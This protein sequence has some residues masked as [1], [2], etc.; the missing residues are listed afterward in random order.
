[1]INRLTKLEIALTMTFSRTLYTLMGCQQYH[2]LLDPMGNGLTK[3]GVL[4]STLYLLVWTLID[5]Q[6]TKFGIAFTTISF[7]ILDVRMRYLQQYP[8][9]D[10]TDNGSTTPGLRMTTI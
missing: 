5:F 10:P 8:I 4:M 2:P 1:M 3:T 6:F 9:M 7:R